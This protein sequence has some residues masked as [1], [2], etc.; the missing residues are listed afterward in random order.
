MKRDESSRRARSGR[1]SRRGESKASPPDGAAPLQFTRRNWLLLS[2]AA[3]V[4]ALG[5]VA[6]SS[7]SAVAS[8]VVAPLLLVAGYGVLIPLGLIL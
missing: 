2:A 5:Y 1:R 3:A 7:G 6:L 8:T 4:V